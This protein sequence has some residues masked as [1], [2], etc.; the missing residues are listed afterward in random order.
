MKAVP[1][2]LDELH[3]QPG[4]PFH[5]MDT[6]SLRPGGW[7]RSRSQDA[8]LLVRKR[9]LLRS[10]HHDVCVHDGLGA[11][12]AA[13]AVAH[14]VGMALDRSLP[15]LEAAALQTANDLCVLTRDGGRW[16]LTS[17][18]V[19][20]PS[21][22]RL[23]DKIGLPVA[24][25]HGP[26]PAYAD[27]LAT[28]VDRFIDRL[29]PGKASWRRNWFIHDTPELFLPT[30]PAPHPDPEVPGGL[31]IRSEMQT[32]ARVEGAE[33]VLFTIRTD[34]APLADVAGRPDLARQ[35]AATIRTWSD[36]LVEY[37]RAAGWRD[38]AIA[39]LERIS[40]DAT[41]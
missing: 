14:H 17:G 30:P 40:E 39:W 37:R 20:F 34:I 27:E 15:P 13:D 2:W 4:P 7:L 3:L 35:M 6:R 11:R 12:E 8:E 29:V 21:M 1:D 38:N 22:W 36:E 41:R 9:E 31:W 18:V 5:A 28:R 32:L 26:V 16:V 33:V 23:P 10:N 19:C 24:L 25:V